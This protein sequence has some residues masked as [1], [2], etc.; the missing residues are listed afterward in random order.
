MN[1]SNPWY[2]HLKF[3]RIHFNWWDS[4]TETMKAASS[5]SRQQ[6]SKYALD[7]TQCKTRSYVQDTPNAQIKKDYFGELPRVKKFT[8]LSF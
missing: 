4:V 8:S 3:L 1:T 2:L 7:L 5:L 6:I